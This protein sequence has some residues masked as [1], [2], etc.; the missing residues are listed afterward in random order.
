MFRS[1]RFGTESLEFRV[2]AYYSTCVRG[3]FGCQNTGM[4]AGEGNIKPSIATHCRKP[5][6]ARHRA[7]SPVL[8]PAMLVPVSVPVLAPRAVLVFPT[9]VAK[10]TS[11]LRSR[12]VG[13]PTFAIRWIGHSGCSSRTHVRFADIYACDR[14]QDR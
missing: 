2:W 6:P 8:N 10:N 5:R 12:S 11:R 4:L 13:S 9:I 7:V 1:E 3:G 14:S